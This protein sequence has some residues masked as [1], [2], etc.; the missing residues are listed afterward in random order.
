MAYSRVVAIGDGSTTQFAVNFA[1]DYLLESDVTCRVGTETDGSGDPLYR[2]ITFLSTNLLQVGGAP[3]ANGVHVVF[4]RTVDKDNLR[5]DYHNGDELDEDNLM[6]AQKQAMMAVHEVLDGRFATLTKDLDAGGF[7]VVNLRDPIDGQDATTKAY[8][9]SLAQPEGVLAAQA[10]AASATASAASASAYKD[11]AS[12]SAIAAATSASD[13]AGYAATVAAAVQVFASREVAITKNLS[14]FT[15]ISTL[16]YYNN[17]PGG[18]ADFVKVAAGQ[19]FLD[20]YVSTFTITGGSGYTPG[21]YYGVPMGG[22]VTGNG[23]IAKVTVN[24]SGV[25]SAVDFS[26][27]PGVAYAIGHVLIPPASYI[28]GTG[29]GASITVTGLTTPTASFVDASGNRWQYVP[30]RGFGV[31]IDQFG[32]KANWDNSDAAATNNFTFIQ[33]ALFFAG[34]HTGTNSDAGG[35]AGDTVHCSTGSYMVTITTASLIVPFGVCV[36]G[37]SG[38]TWKM[39]DGGSGSI[40][41][42]TLG[43]PDSHLACFRSS[44]R[45]ITLFCSRDLATSGNVYMVYSNNIQ[46]CGGLYNVYLYCGNRGG[47]WYEAGYGGAS[48]VCFHNISFNLCGTNPGAKFDVGTTLVDCRQWSCNAPSS[49]INNTTSMV[50]LTNSTWLSGMYSFEG[51]HVEGIPT[52]FNVALANPA[53]VMI[54]NA[55]GGNGCTEIVLLQGTNANGNLSLQNV[56][57]NGATRVVTN[58]QSGGTNRTT[59]VTPK[60]G[61]VFFNP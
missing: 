44:L 46:D 31:H 13:A 52:G 22:S 47:V 14:A 24:G 36:K 5:I 10:A 29:S 34:R 61:I 48:T 33:N 26:K 16:S 11:S 60:D 32:A 9:D 19:P 2:T 18:G 37:S 30:S 39:H 54:R 25:V 40:H 15:R 43:N 35:Y 21:T 3:A 51:F 28:G 17:W 50:V 1:L 27:E 57:K 55:T 12:A 59:D 38:T 8:V 41:F 58:G 42:V 23:M 56:A 4:E 7:S 45:D 53:Q 6:I 49:G 20:E